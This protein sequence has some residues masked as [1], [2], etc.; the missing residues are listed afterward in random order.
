MGAKNGGKDQLLPNREIAIMENILF[1]KASKENDK[2]ILDE[3]AIDKLV[4]K[5]C[6][7]FIIQGKKDKITPIKY[8]EQLKNAMLNGWKR[9]T[10]T[11]KESATLEEV[12]AGTKR[13]YWNSI[14]GKG[15]Y[16]HNSKQSDL[17]K[18]L[19]TIMTQIGQKHKSRDSDRRLLIED[20]AFDHLYSDFEDGSLNMSNVQLLIVTTVVS[21]VISFQSFYWLA[22]V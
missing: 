19:T 20:E 17:K 13:L 8:A 18:Q 21:L 6:K 2:P 12:I 1:Q 5:N 10:K 14:E 4:E 15:H 16:I 11:N 22:N 3:S 9:I 7:M